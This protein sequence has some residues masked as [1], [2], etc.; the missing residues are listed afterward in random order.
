MWVTKVPAHDKRIARAFYCDVLQGQQV[1]TDASGSG[2]NLAF[3]VEGSRID[4]D[5]SAGV[6]DEPLVLSVHNPSAVA[7]R[8]WDAGFSVHVA[9]AARGEPAV[10][11][12]DP[13]GRRINLVPPHD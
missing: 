6:D 4:V 7:A 5:T 12:V 2:A 11:I 13:F 10:F 3:I 8:C 1:W 9:D